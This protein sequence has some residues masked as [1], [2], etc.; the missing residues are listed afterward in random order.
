MASL[1][2][3]HRMKQSFS[4]GSLPHHLKTSQTVSTNSSPHLSWAYVLLHTR[5]C[6]MCQGKQKRSQRKQH[7]YSPQQWLLA[8]LRASA[9]AVPLDLICSASS[10]ALF[11]NFLKSSQIPLI[12]KTSL[13]IPIP[14]PGKDSSQSTSYRLISLLC[15]AAKILEALILPEVN[16]HLLLSPDQHG[17]RPAHST[18]SALLKLTTDIV[19]DFNQRKPPHRT[20]W[21]TVNL[22]AAFDTV[23]HNTSALISKIARST[24]H[25]C[26]GFRSPDTCPRTADQQLHGKITLC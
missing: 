16:N 12:W 7:R 22:T 14:K 10:T 18:T 2:Q 19:T 4:T 13:V 9:T 11:N 23:C 21:V 20:V 6:C 15:P 3:R 17:F 25:H 1:N 26:M 8:Q 5:L 24:Q